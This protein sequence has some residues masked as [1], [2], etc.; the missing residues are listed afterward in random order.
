MA[1][2]LAHFPHFWAKII[3]PKSLV[4]THN[5]VWVSNTMPKFRKKNQW[6]N[7]KKLSGR[8]SGQKKKLLQIKTNAKVVRKCLP[9]VPLVLQ[10]LCMS[11]SWVC[12]DMFRVERKVQC[13]FKSCVYWISKINVCLLDKSKFYFNDNRPCRTGPSLW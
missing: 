12:K 3:F 7:S 9:N 4:V 11:S 10:E 13:E 6:S 2:F 8:K 1:H 5:F